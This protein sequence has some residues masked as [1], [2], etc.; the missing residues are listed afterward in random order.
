MRLYLSGPMSGIPQYNFPAFIQAAKVLRALGHEV[1]SPVELDTD[2]QFNTAFEDQKGETE[3][4][5]WAEYLA[6]DIVAMAEFDPEAIVVLPGWEVSRGAKIET[7]IG[8]QLFCEIYNYEDMLQDPGVLHSLRL[9]PR[10]LAETWSTVP[11][12]EEVAA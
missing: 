2:K 5:A 1:L 7:L 9:L 4:G 10:D 11:L 6:R 12:Y 8:C 3:N